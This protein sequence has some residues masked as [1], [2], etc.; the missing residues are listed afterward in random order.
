MSY[1][2]KFPMVNLKTS[3]GP[4]QVKIVLLRY[5]Q[6]RLP[7]EISVT[8]LSQTTVCK[9]SR[10]VSFV[11][12]RPASGCALFAL[13]RLPS[14]SAARLL[15]RLFPGFLGVYYQCDKCGLISHAL[16]CHLVF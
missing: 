4:Q 7:I 1:T 9:S 6:L 10:E 16:A 5:C 14:A 15:C 13:Y 2:R 11:C 8:G 3:S 12:D